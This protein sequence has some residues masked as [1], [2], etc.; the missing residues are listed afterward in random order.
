MC[1][2]RTVSPEGRRFEPRRPQGADAPTE[3][4][5]GE[6]Q[7]GTGEE[8]PDAPG[9]PWRPPDHL[10]NQ[11]NRFAYAAFSTEHDEVIE[12]EELCD[13]DEL[14]RLRQQPNTG[15]QIKVL[16]VSDAEC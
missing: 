12:A 1:K 8:D 14:G 7:P 11:P 2:A 6:L 13:H 10:H 5:D 3:D 16:I 4:G 9:R 15:F